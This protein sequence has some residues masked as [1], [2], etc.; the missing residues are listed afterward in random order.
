MKPTIIIMVLSLLAWP[1]IAG[2]LSLMHYFAP[3]Y[4]GYTFTKLLQDYEKNTGNKIHIS[5]IDHEAFKTNILVN[6]AFNKLPDVFSYWAGGRS[7]F[8]VDKNNIQNIDSFWK[9]KELDTIIS[10][11]I[12]NAIKSDDGSHRLIPLNY[13]YV[14]MFYNKKIFQKYNLEIPKTW[15]EFLALCQQLSNLNIQ[16]ISLGSLHRWPAQFW[17]DY[18]ML[19]SFGSDYRDYLLNGTI[20]YTDQHVHAVMEKWKFLL[21]N[22]FFNGNAHEIE[23]TEAADNVMENDAAMTLMGTW[24]IGY[25]ERKGYK[26]EEDFDYFQFPVINPDMPRVVLGP[27]DG[28]VISDDAK[29]LETAKDFLYYMISNPKIQKEWITNSSGLSANINLK[30]WEYPSILRRIMIDVN[31]AEEFVFNYD[32]ATNPVIAEYGLALF[33]AFIR[34]PDRLDELLEMVSQDIRRMYSQLTNN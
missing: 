17:F 15:Q 9:E 31:N 25:W 12:S 30:R 20:D 4:G 14:G 8:L 11:I 19:N 16:P 21:D 32:L 3:E 33:D 22:R 18:I 1:S 34:N 26:A 24:I 13:H 6:A 5:D 2:Q 29:N 10:E 7:Q 27:V 28:L 23:W